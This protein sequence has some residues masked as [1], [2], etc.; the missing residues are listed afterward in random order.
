MSLLHWTFLQGWKTSTCA[1]A[2]DICPCHQ[3][4]CFPRKQGM[5]AHCSLPQVTA[6]WM[7]S[8]G[9]WSPLSLSLLLSASILHL[10][11]SGAAAPV[12]TEG[13]HF[14]GGDAW[15][16]FAVPSSPFFLLPFFLA[17]CWPGPISVP[18]ELACS[19]FCVSR[20]E[21]ETAHLCAC[22]QLSRARRRRLAKLKA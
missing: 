12:P 4:C 15:D 3:D 20:L 19:C 7:C 5:S 16:T 10:A 17:C 6:A 1:V 18:Q 22:L 9:C 2:E 8:Q 14:R 11:G 21:G 13:D